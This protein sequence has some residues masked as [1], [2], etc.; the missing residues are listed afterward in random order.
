[1][2]VL[3]FLASTKV[4]WTADAIATGDFVTIY[5]KEFHLSNEN[6]HGESQYSFAEFPYKRKLVHSAITE[7]A[8]ESLVEIHNS[9]SGFT[10]K[11]SPKGLDFSE[12]F[13]YN[14]A[15]D[16]SKQ[17]I[18]VGEFLQEKSEDEILEFIIKKS[19]N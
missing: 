14:Y 3:L 5:S 4:C 10:Y 8:R 17:A 15:K 6:L 7:L 13:Q 2:R 16:Y 1:M 19:V 18:I 12:S 11:I 9:S